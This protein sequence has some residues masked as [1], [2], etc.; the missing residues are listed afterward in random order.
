MN[1]SVMDLQ[2]PQDKAPMASPAP[3]ELS[4]DIPPIRPRQSAAIPR[5]L[6]RPGVFKNKRYDLRPL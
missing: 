1:I 5:K 4:Q 3:T 6:K 2:D